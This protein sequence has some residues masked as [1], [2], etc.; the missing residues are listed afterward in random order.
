MNGMMIDFSLI[1][2]SLGLST[3]DTK[4]SKRIWDCS[5]V[6]SDWKRLS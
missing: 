4:K 5:L 2:Q 6:K 1:C 3:H